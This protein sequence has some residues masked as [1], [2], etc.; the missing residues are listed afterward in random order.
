MKKLTK[1]ELD[2]ILWLHEEWAYFSGNRGERADLSGTDLSDEALA[3]INLSQANLSDANLMG[4]DL[5]GTNLA[6]AVLT[7]ANLSSSLLS[8]SDL[9]S[10]DLRGARILYADLQYA[11]MSYANFRSAILHQSDLRHADLEYASLVLADFSMAKLDGAHLDHA[12][13]DTTT[14]LPFI[15]LVCPDTGS[16]VAWKGCVTPLGTGCV[17]K[18]QIPEDAMRSSSNSRKCRC[19][20]AIV[21]EIQHLDGSILSEFREVHSW[22]N[23]DFM[24]K[25]GE[26]VSVDNFDKNRFN[27]CSTGIH[28]FITREEAVR[29]AKC[30]VNSG[31][32]YSHGTQWIWIGRGSWK[33]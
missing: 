5:R 1:D 19:S 17:V 3:G 7:R 12:K 20:S 10:A 13:I 11:C 23:P 6:N 27:E 28:F 4:A 8:H 16:F 15:P 33:A 29:Y 24:Y 31:R 26:T 32:I 21:L 9:S 25:I 22:R 18:L 14:K 30:R 2:R